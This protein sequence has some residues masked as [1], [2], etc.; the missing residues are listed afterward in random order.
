MSYSIPNIDFLKICPSKSLSFKN[1]LF[2]NDYTFWTQ[3]SKNSEILLNLSKLDYI[4]HDGA[5][6]VAYIVALRNHLNFKTFIS[7]PIKS[8]VLGF[9]KSINFN[10]LADGINTHFLDNAIIYNTEK[11]YTHSNEIERE[12]SR[13]ITING[14]S[15]SISF[16][17]IGFLLNDYI[18]VSQIQ[19]ASQANISHLFNAN[20][21]TPITELIKNI[22]DYGGVSYGDG[23]GYCSLIPPVKNSS[24][25]RYCF[26]DIGKG[27]RQTLLEKDDEDDINKL[28]KI[29]NDEEAIIKG[30]LFRKTIVK[31]K[32]IGLYPVLGIICATKGSI[33]VRSGSS[34]VEINFQNQ[35]KFENFKEY[36]MTKSSDSIDDCLTFLSNGIVAPTSCFLIPGSQIYID[37]GINFIDYELLNFIEKNLA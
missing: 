14:S 24:F 33:G 17:R 1:F 27:F 16:E 15:L 4:Q 23:I 22:I 34:I 35:Q 36:F 29:S 32:I 19:K 8:N 30:L 18:K 21:T 37:L 13:L 26:V 2:L 25:L 7:L 12:L 5:I 6:W 20:F 9:L 3:I 31:E 28:G 10:Y 11:T